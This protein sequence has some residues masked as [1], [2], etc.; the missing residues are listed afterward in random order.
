MARLTGREH[1][2]VA[3][4]KPGHLGERGRGQAE[5]DGGQ[6]QRRHRGHGGQRRTH[7][8]SLLLP[9]EHRKLEIYSTARDLNVGGHLNKTFLHW[10]EE[11]TLKYL[12]TKTFQITF[13]F[14]PC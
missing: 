2:A 1:C 14:S 10:V 5:E 8:T 9:G 12:I 6:A 3:E 4:V 7:G 11:M 13:I